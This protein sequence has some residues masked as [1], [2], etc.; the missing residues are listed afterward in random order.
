VRR[1]AVV[2]AVLTALG[3]V[4]LAKA[5]GKAAARSAGK[6]SKTKT[7]K[8]SPDAK[9]CLAALD[10]LKVPYKKAG[11]HKGID[12]PVK[13]TGA[14]GGITYKTWHKRDLVLDCS[15]VYSLAK[16]GA[17]F[18]D[19]GYTGAFYSSAYQRRNVKGTNRPSNHSYGLAL[20]VH[21]WTGKDKTELAVKDFFEV[22]LGDEA[23]C[24][25]EP[26]TEEGRALKT[27]WCRM[28]RSGLF[29]F[30]LNPDSDAEHWNHYH[31]EVLH[32]RDRTDVPVAKA[33]KKTAK[34]TAKKGDPEKAAEKAE[35]EQAA[36]A[37]DEAE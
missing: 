11:A 35:P 10:T 1:L 2:L 31:L 8:L 20:D 25:G 6:S 32:W 36:E 28:D 22:G 13:V 9:A 18:T 4:A 16:A 29:R 30:V 7:D 27:L 26:E 23:N 14:V 5:G 15:L 12:I 34:K 19:E 17:Y 37:S 21:S 33:S 3:G 24:I